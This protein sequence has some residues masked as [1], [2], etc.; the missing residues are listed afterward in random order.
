MLKA[1]DVARMVDTTLK[2]FGRLD[3]L[4]NNA[5]ASPSAARAR[6]QRGRLPEDAR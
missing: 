5:E 6:A 4:V 3:I 1:A 2:T